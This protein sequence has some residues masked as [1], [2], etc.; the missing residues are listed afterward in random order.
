MENKETEVIIKGVFGLIQV[1]FG[2]WLLS[3]GIQLL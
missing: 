2:I 3:I 1:I